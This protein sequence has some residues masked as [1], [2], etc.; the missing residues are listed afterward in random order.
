ML[1]RKLKTSEIA[2]VRANLMKAQGGICPLCVEPIERPALDHCHSKGHIREVLCM[3]C[4]QME[5][6]VRSFGVRARRHLTYLGWLSNLLNYCTKHVEP[7]NDMIHPLFK[8][9]DEKKVVAAK[10][11]AAKAAL[12]KKSKYPPSTTQETS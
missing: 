8:T 2:Q 12:C 11:R 10:K 1:T 5:G 9:P 7:Q 3:N 6:R 4:N